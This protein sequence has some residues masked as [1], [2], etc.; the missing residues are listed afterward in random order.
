MKTKPNLQQLLGL[1]SAC[2]FLTLSACGGGSGSSP[3]AEAGEEQAELLVSLTDAEGDFLTYAVDL[4]SLTFERENGATVEVLPEETRVDFAQYVDVSELLA[5][6]IVPPGRYDSVSLNLDF[7]AAQITVQSEEGEPIPA[8]ALDTEGNIL[9]EY[10]VEM[11]LE[12]GFRINRGVLAHVVLDFDLDA[13]NTITIDTDEAE[14][15]VEPVF[16]VDTLVD[17]PK[18]FRLRGLLD[19]VN[20]EESVF[21]LEL[22]PFNKRAGRYGDIRIFVDEDTVFEIDAESVANEF[23]LTELEALDQGAAVV[24]SGAW[25]TEERRFIAAQVLAGTSVPWDDSDI[26]RGTVISRSENSVT[27]RGAIVELDTGA[28]SFHRDISFELT[29]DTPVFV[30]GDEVGIDAISIGSAVRATGELIDDETWDLSSGVL[31]VSRSS[32]S[33]QV[34]STAPL[35]LS[36]NFI[37]GR[38]ADLFDFSGTGTTEDADADPTFYE[39]ALRRSASREIENNDP[40]RA[41]GFAQNFGQAPEDFDVQ[42]LVNAVDVKGHMVISYGENGADEVLTV[43]E[44]NDLVFDLEAALG[45]HHISR[46]GIPVDLKTFDEVPVVSPDETSGVFSITGGQRI[47]MF[48]DYALFVES[49]LL[50][51]EAGAQISRFDAH[52]YYENM[53]NSFTSRRIRIHLSYEDT[54]ATD[55]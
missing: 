40:L 7:S 10:S 46:V 35:A 47:Q 9:G 5:K 31:R 38:R 6:V 29:E 25:N 34:V 36:L 18:P 26:M 24:V 2:I 17:D 1:L 33:G 41:F 14:V 15:V 21:T 48:R 44:A 37:N 12:E 53:D 13:S 22:R 11:D 45:R 4:Q 19:E 8:T 50:E 3:S 39:L 51:L 43:T 30:L 42:T 49:V 28:Y 16:L 52:G 32:V 23:G 20:E 54:E 55:S 27:V